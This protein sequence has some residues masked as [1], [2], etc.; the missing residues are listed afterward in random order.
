[1]NTYCLVGALLPYAPFESH[2]WYDKL[3]PYM[4]SPYE[5]IKHHDGLCVLFDGMNG[6]YVAIG[7]VIAKT[8]NHCGFEEPIEVPSGALPEL[9]NLEQKIRRLVPDDVPV[10]IGR[11]VISHFC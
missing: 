6:K 8:G 7:H 3:E 2:G 9:P 4:D 11:Y 5:G 10:R 1:M